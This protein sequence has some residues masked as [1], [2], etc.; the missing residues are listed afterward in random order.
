[1]PLLGAAQAYQNASEVKQTEPL[2]GLSEISASN[3][4]YM[5]WA[6]DN[7]FRNQIVDYL[8]SGA[9]GRLFATR[10]HHRCVCPFT[11]LDGYGIE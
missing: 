4:L 7:I 10:W 5:L 3:E 9:T 6:E 8:P 11:N 1:M 2:A